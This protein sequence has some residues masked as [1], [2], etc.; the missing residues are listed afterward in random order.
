MMAVKKNEEESKMAKTILN[1]ISDHHL[2]LVT[3][4]VYNAIAL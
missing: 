4:L 1:V 2:F 3:L